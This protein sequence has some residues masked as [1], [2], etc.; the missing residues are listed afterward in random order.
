MSATM[1]WLGALAYRLTTPLA[2]LIVRTFFRRVEVRGRDHVPAA[3]FIVGANH[4]NML[5]D[6]LLVGAA[7]LPR[8]VH[9]LAK[10]PLFKI[11]LVGQL[12][13]LLG[14][15][16]VYRRQDF[17]DKMDQNKEMFAACIEALH[18]GESIGIF[19]EGVSAKEPWLQPLKTGAA[20]ILLDAL[21]SAPPDRPMYLLPVGLNYRDRTVFR[22]DVL[23]LFGPPLDPRPYLE[24]FRDDERGAVKALTEALENSLHTLTR[25]LAR[26]EDERVIE[27]LEKVYRGEIFPVPD[28][29]E[30][31]FYLSRNIVDGFEYFRGAKPLRVAE[32]E[33]KLDRY[34]AGLEAFDLSGAQ[35]ASRARGHGLGRVVV[36]LLRVVPPLVLATPVALYGLVM[37]FLPYNL[38]DPLARRAG[39]GVEELATHKVLWGT[40]LFLLFYVAQ[41]LYVWLGWGPLAG[42]LYVASLPPSGFVALWWLERIRHLAKHARTFWIFVLRRGFRERMDRLRRE[43]VADLDQLAEEYLQVRE[44]RQK[45]GS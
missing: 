27:R 42:L 21:D 14:V 15:L 19:P 29:P 18:R 44:R 7:L 8:Q 10:A 43:L 6:P 16:P 2:L 45:E 31:H 30:E 41:T 28:S 32:V 38:T 3:P 24:R 33:A 11:P 40:C 12:F 4:P 9:F 1:R 22:S 20:R 35:L 26:A 23:V 5:L 37:N 13:H 34:F 17:P 36:F 39:E 25:N